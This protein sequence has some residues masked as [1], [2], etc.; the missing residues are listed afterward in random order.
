MADDISLPGI[1]LRPESPRDELFIRRLILETV[2]A[3]L[4]ASAWPEPMRSHL[5]GIQCTARRQSHRM[6]FPEGAS[7]VIQADGA[8]AGWVVAAAMPH[9]VR[10]VEIMVR[11]ELRGRGI[12]TAVIRQIQAMARDAD[13]PVRLS[14]NVTNR[15]A[16]R[17]YQRLGFRGI[18]QDEVQCLME[19][20]FTDQSLTSQ[21]IFQN[22]QSTH[23]DSRQTPPAGAAS[24]NDSQPARL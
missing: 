12:G 22:K 5:L 1:Y 9:D 16:I 7:L 19:A 13:K 3:E 20:C 10:V 15:G 23:A 17:L 14:V 11:P 4:G 8:D 6:N 18:E 21:P 24:G 2:A